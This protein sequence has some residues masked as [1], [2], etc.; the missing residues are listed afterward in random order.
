M[1]AYAWRTGRIEFGNRVPAGALPIAEGAEDFLKGV[2]NALAR[3]SYI[4]TPLAPGVPEA[5]DDDA[6]VDAL[7]KF[8]EAVA[9]RIQKLNHGL[10]TA[11]ANHA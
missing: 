8:N 11:E 9:E 3:Q 5:V 6:A 2:V 7:L 10:T 4:G 1:K